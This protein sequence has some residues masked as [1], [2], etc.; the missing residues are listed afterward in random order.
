MG[1]GQIE[2]DLAVREW[3]T[4]NSLVLKSSKE[5]EIAIQYLNPSFI[6]NSED[7]AIAKNKILFNVQDIAS[8]YAAEYNIDFIEAEHTA[9]ITFKSE[10]VRHDAAARYYDLVSLGYRI[11]TEQFRELQ[12]L[13]KKFGFV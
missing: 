6:F 4:Q 11:T 9:V 13:K 1:L 3:A 12:L 7:L 5:N 2:F 10:L 8:K